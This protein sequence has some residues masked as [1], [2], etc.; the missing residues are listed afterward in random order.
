MKNLLI[1]HTRYIERGGEDVAVDNE[2]DFLENFFNVEVIY[3]Q[4]T[5]P[6]KFNDI[7]SLIIGENSQSVNKLSA[8][9]TNFNP[10]FIII[11]NLWFK[12]SVGVL[13]YCLKNNLNTYIKLHNYRYSCTSNYLSKKHLN[14]KKICSAC[15]LESSK[16]GVFNKYYQESTLKSLFAINFAKKFIKLLKNNN[17]KILT[18]TNHHKNHLID[19]GF[20]KSK[21]F[22]QPNPISKESLSMN[23]ESK[24]LNQIV[25]AGRISSEKGLIELIE[26]WN[27]LEDNL[28]KLL[29]LGDGPLLPE[30]KK[31]TSKT[32]EIKGYV[33]NDEVLK[34]ISQS[35]AVVTATK[36]LEGQPTLLCEASVLETPSLFPDVGG[37]KDFFPKNYKYTF[38]QYDYEDLH[39]KL[40]LI[41]KNPFDIDQGKK[42][43][44][45]LF[46]SLNN[47]Q[48]HLSLK[49]ALKE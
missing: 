19:L 38:K 30:L 36:L 16:V 7:I 34:I 31:Y 47:N 35:K 10:D 49:E 9:L 11:N 48:L 43:R 42:N 25:Y 40:K 27:N 4:N 15:G 44:E 22:L 33:D 5:I 3:F 26:S 29:L 41:A 8:K 46:K 21:I 12:G 20:D 28:C 37:I 14:G 45:H 2:V 24:R 1:I 39:E 32:I 13:R 18:L 6:R 17:L 23:L